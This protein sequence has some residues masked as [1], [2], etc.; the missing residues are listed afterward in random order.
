MPEPVASDVLVRL[1]TGEYV[2]AN[3]MADGT[4]TTT[5]YK[6]MTGA[7][8]TAVSISGLT[9]AQALAAIVAKV[10]EIVTRMNAWTGT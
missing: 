9:T 7:A 2:R 6:P 5:P 4:L 3:R 1:A 10:N 8:I